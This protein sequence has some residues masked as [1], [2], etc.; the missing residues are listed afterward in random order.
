M[1]FRYSQCY[2]DRPATVLWLR[3]QGVDVRVTVPVWDYHLSLRSPQSRC[4][5]GSETPRGLPVGGGGGVV[6]DDTALVA[7]AIAVPT[8]LSRLRHGRGKRGR[9]AP[10][11]SAPSRF[12]SAHER[13][14]LSGRAQRRTRRILPAGRRN[15]NVADPG[16]TCATNAVIIS[17]RTKERRRI[18]SA[19]RAGP[20]ASAPSAAASTSR[21]LST[22]WVSHECS[23]RVSVIMPIYNAAAYLREAIESVLAQTFREFELIAV[24]D[25]FDRLFNLVK[26][27]RQMA[28]RDPQACM[29]SLCTATPDRYRPPQRGDSSPARDVISAVSSRCG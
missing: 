3:E 9:A 27:A 26:S 18:A 19:G 10:H 4:A 29:S 13:R 12:R 24:D 8:I 20:P 23:A 25:D 7:L 15:R 2:A 11:A 22:S 6:L 14:L 21:R 5:A 17:P 16:G 1:S 28:A